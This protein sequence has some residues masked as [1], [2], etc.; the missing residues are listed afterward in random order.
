M[1]QKFKGQLA[2]LMAKLNTTEP[3]YVRCIKPNA[4]N[5]PSLFEVRERCAALL[6][7]LRQRHRARS[8]IECPARTQLRTR[9]YSASERNG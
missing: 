2:D 9:H 8:Y 3:H 7:R 6:L 1:G 4:L 5:R